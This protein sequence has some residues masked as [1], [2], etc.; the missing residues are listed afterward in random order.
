MQ[1]IKK[2]LVYTITAGGIGEKY[3]DDVMLRFT[4][5]EVRSNVMVGE[6]VM[7]N[8]LSMTADKTFWDVQ[9]SMTTENFDTIFRQRSGSMKP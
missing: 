7:R 3:P 9:P 8:L 6:Y 1:E 5:G 2:I 4:G